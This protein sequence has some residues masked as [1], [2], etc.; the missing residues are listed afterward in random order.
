[1][2]HFTGCGFQ[3]FLSR[4]GYRKHNVLVQEQGVKFKQRAEFCNRCFSSG[5]YTVYPKHNNRYIKYNIVNEKYATEFVKNRYGFPA[6]S[7][8]QGIILKLFL[9]RNR[10]RIWGSYPG[11]TITLPTAG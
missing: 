8:E 5:Y 10:V 11:V 3:A 1:M 7:Q 9:V 4:T 2:C 6:L